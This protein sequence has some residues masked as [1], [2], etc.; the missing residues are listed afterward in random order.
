[1]G[2]ERSGGRDKES[3]LTDSMEAIFGAV[4]LDAGL[5]AARAV[6]LPLVRA[7]HVTVTRVARADPKTEL[8]ELAQAQGWP[9]PDYRVSNEE[10]PDHQKLFTVECWVNGELVGTG[11]ERSKKKAEQRAASEG[12]ERVRAALAATP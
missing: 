8:Q 10:G 4:Y 7:R 6:I 9:L 12:L 2:E 3:L 1:V 5:E 11:T